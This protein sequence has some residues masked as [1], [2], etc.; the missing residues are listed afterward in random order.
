M[1]SAE[2]KVRQAIAFGLLYGGID[3]G[4]HKQWLIDQMLRILLGEEYEERIADWES[5]ED[6][7]KTYSWD[8][9]VAP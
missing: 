1:A 3:C 8:E 2:H 9:G 5:G 6:G 4:H 7:P